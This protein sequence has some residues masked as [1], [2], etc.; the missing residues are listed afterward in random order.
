MKE[1]KQKFT[2]REISVLKLISEGLMDKEIAE[3]LHITW[4]SVR[5]D[6][7]KL[8]L[9][10]QSRNRPHIVNWAYKNGILKVK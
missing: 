2:P 7:A 3:E 1:K 8:L 4:Q 5:Y 6:I 9:K 10:T